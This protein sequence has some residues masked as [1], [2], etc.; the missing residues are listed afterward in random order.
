MS[1]DPYKLLNTLCFV[2]LLGLTFPRETARL[3]GW[4]MSLIDYTPLYESVRR[5]TQAVR[6][7]RVNPHLAP[8]IG[9]VHAQP[10][11]SPGEALRAIQQ[12]TRQTVVRRSLTAFAILAVLVTLAV[13]TGFYPGLAFLLFCSACLGIAG[14]ALRQLD[15]IV[16]VPDPIPTPGDTYRG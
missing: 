2:F 9:G 14:W 10:R 4:T 15:A 16:T 7:I 13:T 3:K 1:L 8:T 11:V 12:A 5:Q 6:G